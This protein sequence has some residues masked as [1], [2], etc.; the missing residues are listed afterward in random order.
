MCCDWDDESE[1]SKWRDPS[2][3]AA[4]GVVCIVTSLILLSITQENSMIKAIKELL[5]DYYG[6]DGVSE[7]HRQQIAEFI[8]SYRSEILDILKADDLD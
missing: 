6:P 5:K 4:M 1:Y 3:Y 2:W 7:E 8:R